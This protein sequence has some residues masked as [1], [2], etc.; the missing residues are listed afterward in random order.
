MID[1]NKEDWIINNGNVFELPETE[2]AP[3]SAIQYE[4]L[5]QIEG[6]NIASIL[7]FLNAE[8]DTQK[9]IMF[10]KGLNIDTIFSNYL[11]LDI[12]PLKTMKVPVFSIYEWLTLNLFKRLAD[13]DHFSETDTYKEKYQTIKNNWL[14]QNIDTDEKDFVNNE[15]AKCETIILELQ[16]PIYNKLLFSEV[17]PEPTEF[18]RNLTNIIDKRIKF[19]NETLTTFEAKKLP[20]Q[21]PET[22]KPDETYKTQ[23]LFKV[24]L[25]FAKGE[26]NKYFTVNSKGET[27]MNNGFTAP[28]IARELGD[29]GYNKYILATI[30][31]YT[32]DKENGRKNIFNS[33]DM[34]SKII[35]H[36]EAE[37]IAVDTYFR[38]RLP[39]E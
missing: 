11:E 22:D 26:M 15:L 17:Q 24:G 23:L 34:M 2:S 32:P 14:N 13:N 31:N 36:C 21:Q 9:T 37:N 3:I 5:K 4:I 28:K 29:E 20:L 25:L 33:F 1:F 39:I 18:K 30:N 10:T 19:L 38:S 16:K 35:T 6:K 7:D 12:N 8:I 27:V